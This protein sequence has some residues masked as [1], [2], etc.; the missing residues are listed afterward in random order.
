MKDLQNTRE[1]RDER[2]WVNRMKEEIKIN[3]MLRIPKKNVN[4]GSY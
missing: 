4:D 2:W 3:K 1:L